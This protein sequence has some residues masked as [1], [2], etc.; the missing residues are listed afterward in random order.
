MK[1]RMEKILDTARARGGYVRDWVEAGGPYPA[2]SVWRGFPGI[3]LDEKGGGGV[4]SSFRGNGFGILRRLMAGKDIYFNP[5]RFPDPKRFP[6]GSLKEFCAEH[7]IVL[8]TRTV[9]AV[10]LNP[11]NHVLLISADGHSAEWLG[12]FVTQIP[13][14]FLKSLRRWAKV[15]QGAFEGPR[16]IKFAATM[17]D[18]SYLP[19]SPTREEAQKR[20]REYGP[21]DG[22]P[23]SLLEAVNE[24]IDRLKPQTDIRSMYKDVVEKEPSRPKV[25]EV[26]KGS[27]EPT[28]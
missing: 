4:V 14:G 9:T 22:W 13:Y 7:R 28:S 2:I 26:R 23:D 8:V 12:S 1:K 17:A 18:I 25:K 6:K 5:P 3:F 21:T 11:R 24:V 10:S 20:L 16:L 19:L 27:E 15:A